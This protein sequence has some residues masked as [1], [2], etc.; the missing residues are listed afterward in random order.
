LNL[1]LPKPSFVHAK[2]GS[3]LGFRPGVSTNQ[4]T[5]PEVNDDYQEMNMG[6]EELNKEPD[7]GR[8]QSK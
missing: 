3:T 2:T 5:I 4:R 7:G 1:K 6:G 8:H